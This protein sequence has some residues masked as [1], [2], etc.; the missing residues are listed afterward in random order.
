MFGTIAIV[1][2]QYS[3]CP[4]L[5]PLSRNSEA[6]ALKDAVEDALKAGVIKVHGV[7]VS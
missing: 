7:G 1:T 3:V 5:R 6:Q 2:A 4:S